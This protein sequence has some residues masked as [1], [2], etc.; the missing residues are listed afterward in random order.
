[1]VAG[2][3]VAFA[4][5]V[6][7]KWGGGHVVGQSDDVPIEDAGR[8]DRLNE[9]EFPAVTLA[10]F[11]FK[12]KPAIADVARLHIF[13]GRRP[14]ALLVGFFRDYRLV[15]ENQAVRALAVFLAQALLQG[16]FGIDASEDSLR[17]GR[18]QLNLLGFQRRP[19]RR[20]VL[21][22]RVKVGRLNGRS[23]R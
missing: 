8:D 9:A 13:G 4:V 17:T 12:V 20:L 14:R 21:L 1:W 11:L 15:G 3:A 10:V 23:P 22:L 18:L 6:P 5:V 7:A 16:R 19:L 2:E